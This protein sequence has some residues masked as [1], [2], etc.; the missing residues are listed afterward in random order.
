MLKYLEAYPFELFVATNGLEAV[1]IAKREKLDLVLMDLR[2]PELDGYEATQVIK[3]NQDVKVI[4]LTASALE[5]KE[6]REK[7]KIFDAF[8]RKPI[9]KSNLVST[10]AKF[11]SCK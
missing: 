4:A 5:D 1:E 8:L 6:S 11:I 10:M 7:R 9:L 2:M 3:Q